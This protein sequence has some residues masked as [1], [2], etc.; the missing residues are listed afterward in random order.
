MPFICF[1]TN[2]HQVSECITKHDKRNK[3]LQ[4]KKGKNHVVE[5]VKKK[6]RLTLAH[7]KILSPIEIQNF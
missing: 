4:N 5:F 6:E 2:T 7:F 3:N 1:S